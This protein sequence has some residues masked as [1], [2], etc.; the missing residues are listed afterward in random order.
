[1]QNPIISGRKTFYYYLGIW[2]IVICFHIFLLVFS[3]HISVGTAMADSVV[4]N[5]LF[6][7]IGLGLWYPIFYGKDED[8]KL[9]SV[10]I[11]NVV[12]C[13][14]AVGFWLGL[15]YFLLVSMYSTDQIYLGFIRK[16]LPWRAGIG[17]LYYEVIIMVYYLI[18]FYRNNK[19]NLI[20]EAE[21]KALVKESELNSLKS[22]INPHFLFNSLNSIS[23]LTMIEPS[24]AQE[25]IIKLS[26]FLRY[27]TSNKDEKLTSLD[28]EINNINRYLDI[29]KIRFGKRLVV[30][31]DIQEACCKL[32]LPGL[33]LQPLLENAV[34]YGVYESTE[35][36]TIE[37]ACSCN[38]SALSVVIRNEWDPEFQYNKGEGI[39]LRNIRS[40][41]RILYNRD[42]LLTIKKDNRNF[43]VTIIFPQI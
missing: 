19:E 16:S 5:L 23:S 29:E 40:R 14:L 2:F 31:Q 36:S 41:L 34:K 42:D 39:G 18:I 24:K 32:K 12:G 26:E 30:K 27:T 7:S 43:E 8:E 10:I 11:N 25:M 21:L 22:Q 35:G 13:L 4:S 17:L 3:G 15:T 38:S 33:I 20:K 1:M 37:M 9:I 6:G 28:R